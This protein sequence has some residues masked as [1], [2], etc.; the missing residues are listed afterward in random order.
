MYNV[1]IKKKTANLKDKGIISTEY[2][3]Q[4]YLSCVKV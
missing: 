3:G 1:E 2:Y 4:N